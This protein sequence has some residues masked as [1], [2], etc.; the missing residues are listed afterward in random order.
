VLDILLAVG[1]FVGGAVCFW[2]GF[3]AGRLTSHKS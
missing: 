3:Q 2:V 1:C